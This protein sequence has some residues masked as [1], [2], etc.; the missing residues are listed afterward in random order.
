MVWIA[1]GAFFTI[2]TLLATGLGLSYS[3]AAKVFDKKFFLTS[4]H[5]MIP[6]TGMFISI[7]AIVAARQI[8]RFQRLINKRGRELETLL[9]S[10]IFAGLEPYSER[11]PVGTTIGSLFFFAIWVTALFAAI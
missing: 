1:Y 11:A 3:D 4:I 8:V 10:R 2:N 6:V 7:I 9:F 5:V